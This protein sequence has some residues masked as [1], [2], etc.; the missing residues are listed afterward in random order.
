MCMPLIQQRGQSLAEE[1]GQ[2]DHFLEWSTAC[3]TGQRHL[4]VSV[5]GVLA[6]AL[7]SPDL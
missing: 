7:L 3:A 5:M 1:L 4:T 6:A 2:G